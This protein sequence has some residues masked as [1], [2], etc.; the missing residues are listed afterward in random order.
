MKGNIA[1]DAKEIIEEGLKTI[2]TE[3]EGLEYMRDHLG[4]SFAELVELCLEILGKNGKIVV[5]GIGKSGHVGKKIAASLASTGSTSI[6]VHAVEAMHGDLGMISEGDLVLA[7]SYSGESDELLRVILPAKRLGVKVASFTGNEESSLAKLSD[8]HVSIKIPREACPFNLAPTTSSTATLVMGD[9]LAMTLLHF[10]RFTKENYGRLHPAG[11]IG[12]AVTM[13]VSDVMRTGDR[14][15]KVSPDKTIKETI[16]AMTHAHGGSAVV[17][18]PD[19]LLLGIFTD[20][21]FRRKADQDMSI[22]SKKVGDVMTPHPA[23]IRKDEL[24]IEVL[25]MVEKRKIDD[26]VV[27]DSDGKVVGIVDIQDLPGLKLM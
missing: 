12:R 2:R 20:G 15:A 9:A 18:G 27:V 17:T 11:A 16:L 4:G 13:R 19:D 26:I 1:V 21:D 22:L 10:R 8:L 6:F 24:A 7:I 14:L 5:C 3:I 25:R 23:S